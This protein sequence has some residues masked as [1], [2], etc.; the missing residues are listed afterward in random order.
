MSDVGGTRGQSEVIG[1]ILVFAIVIGLLS[2]NQVFLVPQNNG[3]IEFDHSREVQSDMVEFRTGLIEAAASNEPRSA[4]VALGQRYPTRYLAINPAPVSGTLKSVDGGIITA[5]DFSAEA[6]CG[7]GGTPVET[8]FVKY[9][10]DYNYLDSA[11]PSTIEG[12]V[13]YRKGSGEALFDSRQVLIRDNQITL[14][15]VVGDVQ[16]TAIDT[17]TVDLLPSETGR[18]TVSSGSDPVEITLPT[19]LSQSDWDRLL[20]PEMTPSGHVQSVSVSPGPGTVTIELEPPDSAGDY[21]VRCT[22]V[23]LNEQPD[24][25]PSVGPPPGPGGP[26]PGLINPIGPGTVIFQNAQLSTNTSVCGGSSNACQVDVTF[27]NARSTDV[28]IVEARFVYYGVDA[29]GGAGGGASIP[30][31]DIAEYAASP[32]RTTFEILGPEE[33]VNGDTL[34]GGS[35]ETISV[36]FFENPAASFDVDEGDW[37]VLRLTFED[38]STGE[39]FA[40]TYFIPPEE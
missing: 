7:T 36:F 22:T 10:P 12:S 40:G 17:T 18:T 5:D 15:P 23:G 16:T 39:V 35:T 38:Q 14:I 27:E 2:I 32:P 29:Q 8:K 19:E 3:E 34:N 24:V 30:Q 21:S 6:V 13:A 33:P 9:Q 31:P 1:A 28:E 25:S 20:A 37:F 26:G 4:S 11:I